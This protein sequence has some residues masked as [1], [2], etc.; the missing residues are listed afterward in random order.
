MNGLHSELAIPFLSGSVPA[1]KMGD[2]SCTPH[3][4]IGDILY[5]APNA[6][7]KGFSKMELKGT[8]MINQV[9]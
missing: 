2:I 5:S 4:Q 9:A 1:G 3:H 7:L 6:K 8:C